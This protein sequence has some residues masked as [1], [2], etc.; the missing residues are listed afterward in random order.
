MRDL[1]EEAAISDEMSSG[2]EFHPEYDGNGRLVRL[3]LHQTRMDINL[4]Y[5][6]HPGGNYDGPWFQEPGG[7]G[8]NT[9]P[10]AVDSDGRT[11]IGLVPQDRPLQNEDNPVWGVPR[12]FV[13]IDE[14]HDQSAQREYEEETGDVSK[15]LMV[16]LEG[17]GGNPNNAFFDSREGGVRFYAVKIPW[18]MLKANPDGEGFVF[19]REEG[20][21]E[22][23]KLERILGCV[24]F[25]EDIQHL[26]RLG[27]MMTLSTYLRFLAARDR[28]DI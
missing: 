24:F 22:S 14:R 3:R 15:P 20:Q 18:E 8:V 7:G 26:S 21:T 13:D 28:G 19:D 11:F 6:K 10:Y 5:G 4:F 17:D 1:F 16:E 12:G 25:E 2:W 23:Q 9:L 27:D